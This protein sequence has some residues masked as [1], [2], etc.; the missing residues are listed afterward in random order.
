MM[1]TLILLLLI[2]SVV[3]IVVRDMMLKKQIDN[4]LNNAKE[5]ISEVALNLS[6][7]KVLSPI[8]VSNQFLKEKAPEIKSITIYPDNHLEVLFNKLFINNEEK[9]FI[10]SFNSL[11]HLTRGL[12]K[13]Q[14]GDVSIHLLPNQCRD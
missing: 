6:M 2:A 4:E 9:K 3:G 5:I 13:C 1:I 8:T 11:D 12:L 14:S 10:F 7:E